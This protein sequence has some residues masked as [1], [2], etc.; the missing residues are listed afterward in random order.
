MIRETP[1]SRG[2]EASADDLVVIS[3]IAAVWVSASKYKLSVAVVSARR[4]P[5]FAPRDCTLLS[6]V[7][8]RPLEVPP[9]RDATARAHVRGANRTHADS[10]HAGD[11]RP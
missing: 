3:Y 11:S 5:F 10:T 6:S 1:A 9:D 4:C 2:T 8:G 7:P